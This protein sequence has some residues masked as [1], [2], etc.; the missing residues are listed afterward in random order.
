VIKKGGKYLF[1][2]QTGY[3]L[4][5]VVDV[6][7]FEVLLEKAS[8]IP[9]TGLFHTFVQTGAYNEC[10]PCGDAQVIVPRPC[11]VIEWKHELPTTAK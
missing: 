10:E 6:A 1:M 8:W 11:V 7:P 9:D 4:G 5:C 3:W 2:T